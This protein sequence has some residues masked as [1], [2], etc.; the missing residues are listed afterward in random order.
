MTELELLV[1]TS[2]KFVSFMVDLYEKKS[3]SAEFFRKSTRLKVEFIKNNINKT[4]NAE[5]K[6][7][8][9]MILQKY[10]DVPA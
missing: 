5:I 7:H 1:D 8:A 10:H 3:I 2:G 6:K 9:Y 4:K